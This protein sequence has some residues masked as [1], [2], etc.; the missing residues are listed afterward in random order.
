MWYKKTRISKDIT[1]A[2]CGTW[3]IQENLQFLGAFAKLRKATISFVMSFCLSFSPHGTLWLPL[4]GFSLFLFWPFF[5]RSVKRI[6]VLLELEKNDRYFT[7]IPI[8][9][10][11]LVFRWILLRMRNVSG[12]SCR[13]NQK[14]F[15]F[16]LFF[17]QKQSRSWD[18]VEKYFRAGQATDDNTELKSKC[19]VLDTQRGW[20]TSKHG[21]CLL[22]AG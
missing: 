6:L 19:N 16:K 20:R 5:K 13:E 22:R 3:Q 7:W 1:Q 12:K 17:F 2:P 10:F 15:Y 18:T 9:T 8:C 21:A 4:E 14:R 11:M